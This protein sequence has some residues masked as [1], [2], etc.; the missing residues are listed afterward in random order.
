[1]EE[2][3]FANTWNTAE[4]RFYHMS[5]AFQMNMRHSPTPAEQAMWEIV[6]AKRLGGFKFR[7]QHIIGVFIVDFVCIRYRL[8]IEV[9][10]RIHDFQKDYDE[11]RTNYLNTEGFQVIRFKNEAVLNNAEWVKA[12]IIRYLDNL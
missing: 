1:M 11:A 4:P 8:I 9:D 10:G 7:R 5:R 2:D 6:R 3:N 12:E